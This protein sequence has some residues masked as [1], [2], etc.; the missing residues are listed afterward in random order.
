MSS[1]HWRHLLFF[2]LFSLVA[3]RQPKTPTTIDWQPLETGLHYASHSLTASAGHSVSL[4]LLRFDPKRIELQVVTAKDLNQPLGSAR[5]FRQARHGI[6]AINAGYFDP[7]YRPLGL[8]VSQGETISRLRKVDHGIFYIAK[9]KPGLS[10]ARH[11]SPPKQL[12]FAVECGPR[13]I[14]D[15]QPLTFKP[16]LHRRTAIG[17]DQ[18]G[19]VTIV[20]ASGVIGLDDLTAFMAR[21]QQAGGLALRG[22]LNLDGGS[23]TMLELV[24]GEVEA[25]VTSAVQVPVGLVVTRRVSPP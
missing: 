1:R 8:L 16:S 19:L 11:W 7:Q 4:H 20:I 5:D 17:H 18:A 10:H 21:P 12:Q 25:I 24:H 9:D 3:C 14:V 23:S 6:A 22:A 15:G 13:L 2:L